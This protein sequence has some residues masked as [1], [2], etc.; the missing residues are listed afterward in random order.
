MKILCKP[1]KVVGLLA[2]IGALNWGLMAFFHFNL[3]AKIFGDMTMA[4]K[5]IYGLVG[6]AGLMLLFSFF[7]VCPG[8]QKMCA[9]KCATK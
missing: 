4:S 5:V 6:L 7:K 3:V 1:C 8:C 2:G 9:P